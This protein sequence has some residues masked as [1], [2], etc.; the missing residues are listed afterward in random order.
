MVKLRASFGIFREKFKLHL[1]QFPMTSFTNK[2]Y[3]LGA[4]W[5]LKEKD[6][7]ILTLLVSINVFS[8]C[9]VYFV[10]YKV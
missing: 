7:T 9:F 5:D 8:I 3:C 6:V 4:N 1:Y 10:E 2:W